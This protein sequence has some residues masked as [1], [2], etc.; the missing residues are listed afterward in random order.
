MHQ[1]LSS[2]IGVN[3]LEIYISLFQLFHKLNSD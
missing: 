1:S 3:P 2:E